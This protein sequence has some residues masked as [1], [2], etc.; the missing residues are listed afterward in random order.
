MAKT[1]THTKKISPITFVKLPSEPPAALIEE[2]SQKV[3]YNDDAEIG[4]G[5]A[6]I[7]YREIHSFFAEHE[8]TRRTTKRT[9]S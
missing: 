9:P 2:L 3:F 4:V 6:F 7:C 1:K 5:L 8:T